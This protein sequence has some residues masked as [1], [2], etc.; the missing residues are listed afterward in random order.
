MGQ[1]KAEYPPLAE[2][3]S[4][5]LWNERVVR[6]LGDEGRHYARVFDPTEQTGD[7]GMVVHQAFKRSLI[8][9]TNDQADIKGLTLPIR[10]A[11]L[12]Q[13]IDHGMYRLSGADWDLVDS[14]RD[15]LKG[16]HSGEIP[17]WFTNSVASSADDSR[18]LSWA[19][20]PH[21]VDNDIRRKRGRVTVFLRYVVKEYG[22]S[23]TPQQIERLAYLIGEMLPK[24]DA[25][26]FEIVN[27]EELYDC[28]Q[29]DDGPASCMRGETYVQMYADNPDVCEMVIIKRDGEYFGRALLWHTD[30]GKTVLD[31]IYPNSGIHVELL[32]QYAIEQGWDYLQNQSYDEPLVSRATYSVTIRK[33]SNGEY[34]YMDTFRYCYSDD[35]TEPPFVLTNRSGNYHYLLTDTDGDLSH[36]SDVCRHLIE[37]EEGDEDYPYRRE[38]EYCGYGD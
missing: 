17:K 7:G 27:G 19:V 35:I 25:F 34:P 26:A 28:Y 4:L 23:F 38:Y 22:I 12:L 20:E 8:M 15:L 31:R 13:N 6:V 14:F 36:D 1:I 18:Q 16:Y 10:R 37:D 2:I 5:C 3:G 21:F 30:Q 11:E 9:L 32:K 24:R 33:N 29:D